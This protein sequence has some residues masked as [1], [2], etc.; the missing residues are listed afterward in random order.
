MVDNKTWSGWWGLNASK[1]NLGLW[2]GCAVQQRCRGRGGGGS[3]LRGPGARTGH[4]EFTAGAPVMVADSFVGRR[5]AH[6][7]SGEPGLMQ[8]HCNTL[9]PSRLTVAATLYRFSGRSVAMA[10]IELE[11][12]DCSCSG[13]QHKIISAQFRRTDI[14][15]RHSE[16]NGEC[17]PVGTMAIQVSGP[18]IVAHNALQWRIQ[19]STFEHTG[20]V[21][22]FYCKWIRIVLYEKLQIYFKFSSVTN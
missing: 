12:V 7:S 13:A 1:V 6:L 11:Y 21:A 3:V 22:Q 18:P 14:Q 4:W 20:A 2:C 16:S 9:S 10:L 5:A 15:R 17:R 19:S 8:A